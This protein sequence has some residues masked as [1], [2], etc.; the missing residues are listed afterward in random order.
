MPVSLPRPLVRLTAAF[1]VAA[2][3]FLAAPPLPAFAQDAPAKASASAANSRDYV[4][5]FGDSLN[6]FVLE[7]ENLEVDEEPIRPDGRISLPLIGELQASGLTIPQL[8]D[9]I[10]KAYVK[11]FVEPHVVVNVAHFRQLS[12]SVVG[13]V[14]HPNTFPI[15]EP[16]HLLQA[17]GLAGGVTPERGDLHRVLVVRP[18]GEHQ[19]IDLQAVMEG[20]AE[21]NVML[22]DGDT[23]RV[24][25]VDGPDWYRVLPTV[26]NSLSI[27]TSI[28]VILINLK[29]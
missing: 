11:Y 22:Y 27:L 17:I 4:L 12:V 28:V 3:G 21:D 13:L 5:R 8:H 15:P 9:R 18:S 16:I 19:M 29:K 1:L 10:T 20:K 23:V 7:N 24:F 6:V 14:T 26:A 25:E 2:L